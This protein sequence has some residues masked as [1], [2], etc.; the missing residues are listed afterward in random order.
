MEDW[1]IATGYK[2]KIIYKVIN[3][4]LTYISECCINCEFIN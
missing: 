3:A 4:K 1:I 2:N